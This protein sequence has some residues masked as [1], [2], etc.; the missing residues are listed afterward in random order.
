MD[1]YKDGVYK[2]INFTTKPYEDRYN[3]YLAALRRW[4]EHCTTKAPFSDAA[5]IYRR[6]L[7]ADA[8]WVFLFV[9]DTRKSHEIVKRVCWHRSRRQRGRRHSNT[10]W[11]QICRR[12]SLVVLLHQ[13]YSSDTSI[14][15]FVFFFEPTKDHSFNAA[16]LFSTF[17]FIVLSIV[18]MPHHS[19]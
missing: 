19:L 15:R 8:R 9:S 4:N 6:K 13:V 7:F 12:W 14:L 16:V 5:V 2:S 1:E 10:Q 11:R 17:R 3:A 18:I